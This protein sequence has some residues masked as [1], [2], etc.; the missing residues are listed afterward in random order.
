[1]K[2]L[3]KSRKGQYY[4]FFMAVLTI[5]ALAAIFFMVG[6][7]KDSFNE[8]VGLK[9]FELAKLSQESDK[10]LLY[11]D[12]SAKN[13]AW[14]AVWDMAD[15]GGISNTSFAGAY[16]GYNL[17]KP[18]QNILG[19]YDYKQTFVEKTKKNLN[20][21]LVMS[22]G[23]IKQIKTSDA[24]Q[25]NIDFF[26][27]KGRFIDYELLYVNKSLIGSASH[28]MLGIGLRASEVQGEQ[29]LMGAT[30]MYAVDPSFNVDIGY[31][32]DEYQTIITQADSLLRAC[33]QTN[34]FAC[35]EANKPANWAIGN[36]EGM[37][38]DKNSTMF[39]FCV[40]S[41]YKIPVHD[42]T[43]VKIQQPKYKFALDFSQNLFSIT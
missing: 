42:N 13:S 39:R 10:A 14:I 16:H 2:K 32:L 3:K 18:K 19:P 4:F 33:N 7:K 9:A 1:M 6:L 20:R 27:E 28:P 11:L 25:A 29:A 22:Y 31:D 23:Q 30:R 43:Q 5:A 40:S 15:N 17:W 24:S 35:V 36:C 38:A 41:R 34:T 21:F 8:A 37:I 12:V 26:D